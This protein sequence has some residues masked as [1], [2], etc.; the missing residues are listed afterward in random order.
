MYMIK[1]VPA[2]ARKLV[3]L[4]FAAQRNQQLADCPGNVFRLL[5][6]PV[7]A[8]P[9]EATRGPRLPDHFP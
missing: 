1:Q 5:Q 9:Q 4:S 8:G 3:S 7:S 2:D 6:L